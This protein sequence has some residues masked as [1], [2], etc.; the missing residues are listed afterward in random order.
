MVRELASKAAPPGSWEG[1]AGLDP[2]L[3]G[4]FLLCPVPGGPGAKLSVADAEFVLAETQLG[5]GNRWNWFESSW[6]TWLA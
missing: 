1:W 2:F 4:F 5:R 3:V 6:C